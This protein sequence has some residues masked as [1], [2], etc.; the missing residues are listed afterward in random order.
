MSDGERRSVGTAINAFAAV[1]TV[2]DDGGAQCS[3]S[4][5]LASQKF[6]CILNAEL[7]S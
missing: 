1:P 2:E 6:E 4:A 7:Q 3:S 5:F